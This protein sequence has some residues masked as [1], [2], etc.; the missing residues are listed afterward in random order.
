MPENDAEG[1]ILKNFASL[2]EKDCLSKCN[3][4]QKFCYIGLRILFHVFWGNV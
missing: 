2:R 3:E 4:P 1:I